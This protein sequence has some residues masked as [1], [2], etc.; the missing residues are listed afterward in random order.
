MKFQIRCVILWPKNGALGPR[1]V[2]FEPGK[3]NVITG[4]SKT[5]KSAIIPIIDYCLGSDR[6]AI[7]VETI[8]NTTSWFGIVV[9]TDRGQRLLARR[10]PGLQKSTSDMFVLEAQKVDVPN[11]IAEKNTTTDAVKRGLDELSG[12]TQLDFDFDRAGSGFRGRPSFRDQMAFVFQPQNVVA[13]P[14][15]F[16]FKADTYEHREKLKTIFPYVLNAVTPEVLAAQ[17]ELEGVRR[18][19]ARKQRELENLNQVSERWLADLRA[20]ASKG[21]ELGLLDQPVRED[22]TRNQLVAMLRDVLVRT[23]EVTTTRTLI[24]EGVRE[25]VALQRE[26]SQIATQLSVLRR[27]YAEME[28]LRDTGSSYRAALTVQRDR[29]AL[30]E[31][32]RGLVEAD[33]QCPLCDTSLQT[34]DARL[35]ELCSALEVVE[36][37]SQSVGVIP[38]SFEREIVRVKQEIDQ[39]TERLGAVTTRLR[40]LES[41]S[42]AAREQ[43]FRNDAASKFVGGLEQALLTHDAMATDGILPKEVAELR[44]REGALNRR[45][46]SAEIQARVQRALKKIAGYAARLLPDLDTERPDDPLAL[47][48]TDLTIKVEGPERSDYLW[49]IGSGANWLSYHIACSVALQRFFIDNATS[50]V[51]SFLVY[52]QPSQVYFPRRLARTKKSSR[53]DLDP[54]FADEDATAVRKVFATLARVVAELHGSLQVIVLDHASEDIWGRIE[55][56]KLVEEWRGGH[57]LVPE[58]W[59]L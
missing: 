26:D 52:D 46:S 25:L 28:K 22:A 12:L 51:P 11:V 21:R 43:K 55:G 19:L 32:L 9:D 34:G 20:W 6:C 45:I 48:I 53:E 23:P 30:S 41:R 5:G 4:A 18:D 35:E 47:S 16:F 59:L 14:D 33:A 24:E 10:E 42:Q 2:E 17:H 29:L 1:K 15:V 57:K 31:W 39:T 7:P 40:G 56:V 58:T 54:V 3:V 27:R 38:A 37:E 49:E 36:K 44:D 50:P 13:N 8:R